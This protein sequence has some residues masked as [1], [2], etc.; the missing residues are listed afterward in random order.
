MSRQGLNFSLFN[1]G[2]V[3]INKEGGSAGTLWRLKHC[4]EPGIH[5]G[6]VSSVLLG[7]NPSPTDCTSLR[8]HNSRDVLLGHF[9]SF[10]RKAIQFASPQ[11]ALWLGSGCSESGSGSKGET[12]FKSTPLTWTKMLKETQPQGSRLYTVQALEICELLP[13]CAQTTWNKQLPFN[14]IKTQSKEKN[15]KQDQPFEECNR[16]TSSHTA[17]SGAS[18][19]L[20]YCNISV[21]Q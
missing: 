6:C 10:Q 2:Y 12:C 15:V 1:H 18:A 9:A 7:V 13:K 19:V 3:N 4:W 5:I 11:I 20:N 14:S 17:C 16:R 21:P 8:A